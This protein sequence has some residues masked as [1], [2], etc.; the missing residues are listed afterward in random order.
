MIW[1]VAPW[2]I[3]ALAIFRARCLGG[4]QGV[5]GPA[6]R[7]HVKSW[8]PGW[9]RVLS[10]GHRGAKGREC[11][12]TCIGLVSRLGPGETIGAGA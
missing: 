9:G 1:S 12:L 4:L 11:G 3:G 2:W 10:D 8:R 6:V 7:F 5:S